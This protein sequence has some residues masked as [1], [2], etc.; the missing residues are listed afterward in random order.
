MEPFLRAF[1][2]K[3]LDNVMRPKQKQDQ[4]CTFVS[5]ELAS[6]TCSLYA[7]GMIS[8][9][10]AGL[11]TSSAGR[12]GALIIGGMLYLIGTC[13]QTIA[14]NL[15]ILTL[16]RLIAGFGIGFTNQVNA[17]TLINQVF[18]TKL[19]GLW[20]IDLVYRQLRYTSA[21]WLQQHGEVQ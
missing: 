2:P 7:A 15:Y 18:I 5:S 3:V 12:K 11:L 13:L 8:A 10:I 6:Y 14:V 20:D 16:G 17:H 4:F 9:L 21:R 1:F 19:N